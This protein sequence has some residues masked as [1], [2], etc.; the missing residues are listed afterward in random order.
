MVLQLNFVI[1]L[2]SYY[3]NETHMENISGFVIENIKQQK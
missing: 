3:R 2:L 1:L